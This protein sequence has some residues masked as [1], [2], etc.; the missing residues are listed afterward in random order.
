MGF[1]PTGTRIAP[2][3]LR[4][5]VH[6]RI[7][8][9]ESWRYPLRT[10]KVVSDYL[11]ECEARGLAK[12]TIDQ[13]R[14]ALGCMVNNSRGI[15]RRGQQLLPILADSSL[16]PESRKDLIKCRRTSFKWYARQ[17]WPA[18]RGPTNP[19]D[20]LGALPKKRRAPRVL[21]GQEVRQLLT[22]AQTERDRL[23]VSLVMDCGLR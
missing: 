14:W 17:D 3:V 7:L 6:P 2:I 11:E 20:E 4:E 5:L 9:F 8:Q 23:M 12:S 19:I 1:Q 16:S 13:Y 10:S 21:T 15:P 22:V 18:G